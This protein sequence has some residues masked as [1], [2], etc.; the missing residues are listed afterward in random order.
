MAKNPNLNI[1]I[2]DDLGIGLFKYTL[3][4]DEKFIDVNS[5]LVK[6]LGYSSKFEVKR[7]KLSDLFF[8]IVD[9]EDFFNILKKDIVRGYGWDK[10]PMILVE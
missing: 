4:P 3:P 9:K 6:I 5:A 7:K 8:N 2:A 10:E 1:S